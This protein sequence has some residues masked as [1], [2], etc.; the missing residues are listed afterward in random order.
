[1]ARHSGDTEHERQ[2]VMILNRDMAKT[3]NEYW[4]PSDRVLLIKIAGKP[5]DLN[6]IQI[7][8]PTSTSSDEDIEKFYGNLEQAKVQCR[9]QDTLII[10]GDF[11]AKVGEGREDILVGPHGLGIGNM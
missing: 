3:V 10:M 6:I 9:Q 11:N 4:T 1:M 5:Y 7:Y 8:A 2:V